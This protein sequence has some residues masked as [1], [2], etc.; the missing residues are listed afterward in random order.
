MQFKINGYKLFRRDGG[1]FG[2]GSMLYLNEEKTCKFLNNH[3]MVLNA[4]IICI[5]FHQLK[6]KWLFLECY[7]PPT[8]SDLEFIASITKIV[9]FYI[10]K[11]EN[12]F[13]IDDLNITTENTYLNDLLQIYDLSALIQEPT[14]YKSQNHNSIDHFLTNRKT[15]FKHCQTFE[16]GLSDHHKL[17]STIMK[18]GIFKGP[19]KKKIYW[20]YKKFDNECFRNALREELETLEGDTYDEF[21]KKIT[22]VLNTTA[23]I[24]NK[25]IRFNNNVF[26]TKELRKEIMKISKVRSKFKRRECNG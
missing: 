25:M 10:Q 13:I 22:N 24:K 6:H 3:L 12:L 1:Q 2:M 8:Q 17:I 18:S 21:E 11:F 5:E 4:E 14:C 9:G 23:P 20:S 26:M 16:T 15:F 19:H 7:K